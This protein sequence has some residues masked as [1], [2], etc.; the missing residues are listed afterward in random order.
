MFKFF[1][2]SN[3]SSSS[4]VNSGGGGADNNSSMGSVRELQAALLQKDSDLK[5]RDSRISVLEQELRKK[6]DIIKG[7][8]RELDKCKSVLQ[9]TTPTSEKGA[10]PAAAATPTP[11]STVAKTATRQRL[12]GIS[13]EPQRNPAEQGQKG[14]APLKRHSK[15]G[16]YVKIF[17]VPFTFIWNIDTV[18]FKVMYSWSLFF[19]FG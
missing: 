16:R 3:S 18:I 17:L 8:N 14:A 7:L 15:S 5:M 9:P 11:A 6:D 12:Q 1:H 10:S 2:S 19:V 13:A 4:S